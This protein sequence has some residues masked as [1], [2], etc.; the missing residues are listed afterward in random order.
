[1]TTFEQKYLKYKTKYLVL[2]NNL[3]N[4]NN[5]FEVSQLTDTPGRENLD[6]NEL[7]GGSNNI[8]N[9]SHLTDTPVMSNVNTDNLQSG[10]T[11]D[12]LNVFSFFS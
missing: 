8:L 3:Y 7:V 1:M 11:N 9:V 5:I 12:I 6:T 2:K 10:E 4:T